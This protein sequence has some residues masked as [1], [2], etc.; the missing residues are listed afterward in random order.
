MRLENIL[1]F[2]IFLVVILLTFVGLFQ[3]GK[4][5]YKK[6]LLH[7][8]SDTS[9]THLIKDKLMSTTPTL[10]NNLS[11]RF[12]IIGFIAF[13]MLIPLGQINSVVNERSNLHN[14][15][16]SN[17]ASQWGNP[18]TITGPVLVVPIIERYTAQER[19]KDAKGNERL[20][21][22]VIYDHH[23]VVILPKKLDKNITLDEHYRYRSI[24]KSLVY[25]SQIHI[26]GK[27]IIPDFSKLADNLYKV[28][29]DKAYLLMGLSDTKAI[30]HISS[31]SFG[32][33]TY[34]FEPG[35]KFS[36]QGIKGGFH[37]PLELNSTNLDYPFDFNVKT[38]GS[39]YLRFSAFGENTSIKV[40]SS[41][42]HPSFQGDVLPKERNITQ[43]GFTATWKIPS[44]ARNF[45]QAW[46]PEH[47]Q[48][49]VN[50]LLTGVDLYEPVALYT[51]IQRSI[52]YGVLFI[53]LTFLT[54][55]VFE[56]TQKSK[57]HYVQYILIGFSLG[58]FF[59]VLL[60]LSEHLAFLEA[61]LSASTITI[62][63]ISL[64]TWFSNR[65]TK[66]SLTLFVLLSALYSILYSLL[67]LEDYALLM[68]T[69]LLLVILFVLMW[70]TRNIKVSED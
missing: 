28:R 53:L 15:V 22:K 19:V 24:Y 8:K 67:Q 12:I 10:K 27:F 39:S 42:K 44:L 47:T 23:H 4:W 62:L 21:P 38:N 11:L 35:T 59:L 29:Y 69:G 34:S 58:L 57:L 26:K 7:E 31:L 41:W 30:E 40:Q 1:I 43:K 46:I 70:I 2:G 49:R 13:V 51:L 50:T 6:F 48:Y 18:Q 37:A 45:P 64:Y 17:I 54:F 60:S 32:Q 9:S 66:Q 36:L 55:L 63:S 5:G 20:V 14:K 56:I 65:S 3:I 68:G 33:N 61:Y 52:K 16:L 25:T